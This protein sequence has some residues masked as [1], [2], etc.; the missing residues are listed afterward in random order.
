MA[1][2]RVSKMKKRKMNRDEEVYTKKCSGS[3]MKKI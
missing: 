1:E 3:E 2:M